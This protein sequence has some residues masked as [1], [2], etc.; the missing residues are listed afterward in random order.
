[1]TKA[2]YEQMQPLYEKYKNQGFAIAA[3]PC[4]QFGSQEPGSNAD[5]K[6]FAT[7][8]FGAT[9]D[10]YAKIDVNGDDAHPL[11][12]YLKE[13]Q[14][15]TLTDD[16]KWNFTKFLV[17]RDGVPIARY[18]TTWK[19]NDIEPDIIK[20]LAQSASTVKDEI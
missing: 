3:F 20:A 6:Q 10:L 12:K 15:G 1:M 11:W 14:G 19:P 13:H 8:K 2:N 16:I 18:A 4:N 9:Y 7:K 5:I 17:N